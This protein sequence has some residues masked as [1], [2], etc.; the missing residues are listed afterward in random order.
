M[1]PQ[2]GREMDINILLALRPRKIPPT[3]KEIAGYL[4]MSED[5]RKEFNKDNPGFWLHH[6]NPN[7]N[8]PGFFSELRG[9]LMNNQSW[10]DILK[11]ESRE[12]E[13]QNRVPEIMNKIKEFY[14]ELYVGPMIGALPFFK[15]WAL[16]HGEEGAS[17]REVVWQE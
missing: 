4:M 10:V 11:E 16:P 7:S 1:R 8:P 6:D 17:T 15:Q 5:S 12:P 13:Y 2:G 14:R 9:V 3:P